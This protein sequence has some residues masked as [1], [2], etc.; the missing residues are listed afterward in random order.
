M[1]RWISPARSGVCRRLTAYDRS[2]DTHVNN[3]RRK[4]ER[5]G[6]CGIEIRAVR[7]AGYELLETGHA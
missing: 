2:V 4:L 1:S 6:G 7:G 3:L 5:A